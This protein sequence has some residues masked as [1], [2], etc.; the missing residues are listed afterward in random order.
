MRAP[1]FALSLAA[2]ALLSAPASAQEAE[3]GVDIEI[4]KPASDGIGYFSVPSADT[5]GHLQA[6]AA[7]WINY[8]NDPV[9]LTDRQGNRIPASA[10]ADGDAGDGLID[11]RLIGH[12]L[13]GMGITR[14]SSL[15]FDVPVTLNQEGVTAS[16]LGSAAGTQVLS[17]GGLGDVR[18]IPK[19]TA[20]HSS[21][22]PVGLALVVPVS[23]PTGDPATLTGELGVGAAPHIAL[24]FSDAEVRRQEYR[25]RV[26]LTTGYRVRTAG[27]IQDV[28]LGSA[29]TWGLAA[30]LAPAEIIELMAE[31]HG[32]V[33]G[34]RSSQAPAEVL[35]GLK[36]L[37]TSWTTLQIGGGTAI[38][39]GVGAPDYR[40]VAGLSVQPSFD[41]QDRDSDGDEVPDGL[42]RCLDEAEDYDGFQDDDGCPELDNDVDGIPDAND[43][44]P[45]DPED[46][47]GW[48]DNDGCP[49]ADNDKDEIPDVE[50]RC[51]NE[52]ETY[53][54]VQDDD[55][56]PDEELGDKDDDGI[57]DDV[58]RCPY[59]AED[60][61]GDRDDD[62]CP[63]EGRV[64]VEK[65]N[66]KINDTIY[67]DT[68]KDTIQERSFDLLDEIASVINAN[69]QLKKIRI[70]GHTDSV[71]GDLNNLRL[72]QARA[73][74]VLK[75]LVN[76]GIEDG[77]L[78]SRGFGE[79]A[80]I[81][82][83]DTEEGRAA[84]RRVEFLIV[85]QD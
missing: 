82:S 49:D 33:A 25:W 2:L 61:D 46:D 68:G 66:I 60:F 23:V 50:D 12:M 24:E 32:E 56:C 76:K 80:P 16:S 14:W 58:D 41:P 44:C 43:D 70:E 85:D 15:T 1:V 78:E 22:G 6:Q 83:N 65:T 26:G 28:G 67:F 3:E 7:F 73:A 75:Y 4:F 17:G 53:N 35:A 13:F 40:I 34:S 36:I 84:N 11:D 54:N 69:P 8:A 5:L 52:A 74:A 30:A 18:V 62:G 20:L 71:G 38:L 48:L 72:S 81:D 59:D 37:P 64:V 31:V 19:L 39:G 21:D 79:T 51:P 45:M 10:A 55:G 9:V 63:D 27:R 42:D 57:T 29:A 77:R 47:D